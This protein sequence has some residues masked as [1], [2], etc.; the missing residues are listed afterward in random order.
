MR[1]PRFTRTAPEPIQLTADD[2]AIIQY[3]GKHRFLRSTHVARLIPHRSYKK[4]V[5]RLV[6]LYHNS[7]LDRPRAQLDVYAVGGSTPMVYGLGARG[8]Q[9][10]AGHDGRV[11]ADL[12][13]TAKNRS[14]GRVFIDHTLLV[15]DLMVGAACAVRLNRDVELMHDDAI[16]AVAPEST[17]RAPIRGSS[18]PASCRP[19]NSSN[20]PSSPTPCSVSISP[21]SA[22]AGGSSTDQW[23]EIEFVQGVKVGCRLTKD[24]TIAVLC[25]PCRI[26]PA[27]SAPT[28]KLRESVPFSQ[29]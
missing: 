20:W 14:A 21:R 15:A 11:S 5:E 25:A 22:T 16:L 2:L 18:Q 13:W 7:F 10:L 23:V 27:S 4:L 24:C 1:R 9:L 28:W 19:D 17:R 29:R 26:F 8:A 12:D 3:I 6:A